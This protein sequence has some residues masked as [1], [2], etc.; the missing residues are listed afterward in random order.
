MLVRKGGAAQSCLGARVQEQTG[1]WEVGVL[2]KT[3]A[4]RRELRHEPIAP[5]KRVSPHV[6][7]VMTQLGDRVL[8]CTDIYKFKTQSSKFKLT[9]QTLPPVQLGDRVLVRS[10]AGIAKNNE[11]TTSYTQVRAVFRRFLQTFC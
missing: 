8:R 7:T 11:I 4:L 3:G 2:C 1:A 9:P 10:A 6:L 5:C